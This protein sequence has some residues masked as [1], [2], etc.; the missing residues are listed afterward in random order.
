MTEKYCL[1][2]CGEMLTGRQEKFFSHACRMRYKREQTKAH[3][4]REVS[5]GFREVS[6]QITV[7][8]SVVVVFE[9][10]GT[11]PDLDGYYLNRPTMYA[12][13][14]FITDFLANKYPDTRILT[15]KVDRT[16]QKW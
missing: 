16:R 12:L 13:S 10:F 14:Q 8:L 9:T 5:L 11:R 3:T 2:G 15:V 4:K 6:R 1:C 7:E